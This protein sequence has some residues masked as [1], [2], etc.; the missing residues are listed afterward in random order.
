VTNVNSIVGIVVAL[1]IAFCILFVGVLY[2]CCRA[3]RSRRQSRVIKTYGQDFSDPS[4]DMNKTP[5]LVKKLP[6]IQ[7]PS[8]AKVNRPTRYP[9]HSTAT[10]VSRY[11]TIIN[12]IGPSLNNAIPENRLAKNKKYS[13]F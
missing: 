6:I 2:I 8:T 12:Q 9:T 1:S 11:S 13:Y 7:E 3:R 4:D 10:S 5:I